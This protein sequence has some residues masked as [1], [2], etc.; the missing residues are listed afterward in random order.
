MH[1]VTVFNSVLPPLNLIHNFAPFV[2]LSSLR[3]RLNLTCTKVYCRAGEKTGKI[4]GIPC[5]TYQRYDV[6]KIAEADSTSFFSGFFPALI[7]HIVLW[8]K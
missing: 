4:F 3:Q 8:V 6:L 5:R 2:Y 7:E 1:T